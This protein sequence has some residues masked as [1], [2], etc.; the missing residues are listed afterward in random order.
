[1]SV[2]MALAK[3]CACTC[4]GALI[5]GGAVHVTEAPAAPYVKKAE[6]RKKIRGR[7]LKKGASARKVKRTRRTVTTK[8]NHG[9]CT[10]RS[11]DCPGTG[12][13]ADPAASSTIYSA[14]TTGNSCA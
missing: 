14:S 10:E 7:V 6:R 2:R 9:L 8:T 12:G 5:G 11:Y 13:T 1:M 3:L 4:G